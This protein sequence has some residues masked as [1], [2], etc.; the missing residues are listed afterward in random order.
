MI[1]TT[2]NTLVRERLPRKIGVFN[3]VAVRWPRLLDRTDTMPEWKDGTIQSVR[4]T[5]R[6][7]DDV[8]DVGSGFGVAAVWAARIAGSGG[9]VDT[10]EASFERYKVT[11]E[12]IQLNGVQGD[13]IPHHSVVGDDLEIFGEMGNPEKISPAELPECDVLVTDC[14]GA[15]Q[16]IL[17]DLSV[18]N[19]D[20]V[21]IETH[22]FAESPTHKVVDILQEHDY[23]I[24]GKRYAPGEY[25]GEDNMT[26]TARL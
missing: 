22:G 25:H 10:Y 18:I 19:P 21:V 5:V 26:V 2:Y 11:Q 1:K 23:E 8:V 14:E 9:G 24:L 16:R 6:S 15:E 7:G 13:V 3:G 20:R 17:K 4:E 12:T